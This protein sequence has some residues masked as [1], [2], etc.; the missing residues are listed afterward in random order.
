MVEAVYGGRAD[1]ET[2]LLRELVSLGVHAG[3]SE[4]LLR[5]NS[6]IT[7]FNN[8]MVSNTLFSTAIL[9]G[10]FYFIF[11]KDVYPLF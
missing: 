10:Y 4:H 9:Q 8:R 5:P 6:T 7:S 3:M 2:L 11:Y 1:L